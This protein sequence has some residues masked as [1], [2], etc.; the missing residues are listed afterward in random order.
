MFLDTRGQRWHRPSITGFRPLGRRSHSACKE[1]TCEILDLNAYSNHF[2]VFV[3]V[4]YKGSL[5]VFGGF[6]GILQKHYND[7][8]RYDPG[9]Y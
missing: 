7:L 6:N 8:L 9:I 1:I 2:A 5:F 3:L 4:T